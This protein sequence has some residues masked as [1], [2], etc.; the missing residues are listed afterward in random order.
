M[1][2]RLRTVLPLVIVI[3]FALLVRVVYNLTVARGY[4][5]EFDAHHYRD[6]GLNL[7]SQQCFCLPAGVPTVARAPLWPF[8]I[9]ILASIFGPATLYPRLFFCVIGAGTCALTYLFARDFFG[10]RIA[11]FT[12]LLA[13]IYPGLF[14]YDGWLYSE[15]L[16]TFLQLAFC[17]S[18]YRLQYSAKLSWALLSGVCIALGALTR[19]N[20]VS[21]I[22]VVVVWMFVVC[23][24][25]RQQSW[26]FG[27]RSLFISAATA[28]ILILPWTIRNY[29]V[30]HQFIP[31]AVG[32]G[33]VLSGAYNDT[34]LV[35]NPMGR[36]MWMSMSLTK[37]P[38]D[39]RLS[40]IES[41][42]TSYAIHWIK[43]H[44][45]SMPYLLSL[46]FRNMWIPYTSELGL[47]MIQFSSR[48]S[49]QLVS[50]S[51]WIMTPIVIALAVVGLILTWRRW[52]E[53]LVIYL[54]IGLTIVTNVAL[55]GSSR[56]RAPIE[57]LLILFVGACC[58]SILSKDPG[59]LRY[60]LR[61][62]K[63]SS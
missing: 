10:Q 8:I 2:Q 5:P 47:P 58:W 13:S 22:A 23:T 45:S 16:Y 50:D 6:I 3:S 60:Y 19:P 33:A 26:L 28:I 11:I 12:G 51:I 15:S 37:P 30:A 32:S 18:L 53:F 36:G 43:T 63:W 52:K 7:L 41:Y 40:S 31:V 1:R 62:K 14:I 25:A 20:G 4:S 34:V 49:S 61:N 9:A 35:D 48:I 46:H 21:L 17:Y 56:F 29:L 54:V 39:P 57:P 24:I 38:L 59:T 55:Y 27:L 42:R 44:L